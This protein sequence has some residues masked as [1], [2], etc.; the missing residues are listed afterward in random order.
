MTEQAK[1][2][3]SCGEYSRGVSW[4]PLRKWWQSSRL[5]GQDVG[6]LPFLGPWEPLWMDMDWYQKSLEACSWQ[7]YIPAP[8][9]VPY[10]SVSKSHPSQMINK[11]Q[12]RWGVSL[13]MAHFSPSEISLRVTD[14]FLEVRGREHSLN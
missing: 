3:L 11:E 1:T 14:G 10:I 8:L 13:D 2:E 9:F 6:L 12:Y 5:Y 7:G 4:Y